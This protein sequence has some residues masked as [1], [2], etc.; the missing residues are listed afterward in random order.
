[1][2]H[3]TTQNRATAWAPTAWASTALLSCTAALVLATTASAATPP[4]R[5]AA[6]AAPP[7]LSTEQLDAAARV[8]VGTASCDDNEKV[9]VTPVANQ[10]GYF[11][12]SHGKNSYVLTPKPTTTGAVRLEDAKSGMVWLQ[13]PSKSML[14]NAKQGRRVVDACQMAEQ[15]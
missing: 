8:M 11:R 5:G 13:I 7:A 2:T 14:M 3:N 6:A 12:L 10:P 15:R 1:M 4:K 9:Q